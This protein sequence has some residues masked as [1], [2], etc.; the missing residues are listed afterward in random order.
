MHPAPSTV[1]AAVTAARQ[2]SQ[3]SPSGSGAPELPT[4]LSRAR[5]AELMHMMAE[6]KLDSTDL[7][8]P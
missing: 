3:G 1:L 4:P 8:V 7:T 2:Q 6:R 5:R